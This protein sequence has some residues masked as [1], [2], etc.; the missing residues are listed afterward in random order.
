MLT[1]GPNGSSRGIASIIFSKP[2][3]A[4]KAA[5][6]LNGL[7]VDGKPMKVR[8]SNLAYLR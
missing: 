6:E 5:R 7:L 3:T 4:A 8:T 1:Y 2:D